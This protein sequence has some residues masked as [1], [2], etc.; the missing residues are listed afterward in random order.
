MVQTPKTRR[1]LPCWREVFASDHNFV[2][3]GKDCVPVGPEPIP[4]GVC[5]GYQPRPDVQGLLGMEEDLGIPALMVS[6]RT[7]RLIS[8]HKVCFSSL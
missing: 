7:K 1:G 8:V 2:R 4:A 3:N 5:T 6:R